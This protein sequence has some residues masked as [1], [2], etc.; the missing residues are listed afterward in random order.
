MSLALVAP[1]VS[2]T[3]GGERLLVAGESAADQFLASAF[4]HPAAGW[5]IQ[6]PLPPR[7]SD[8]PTVVPVDSGLAVGAAHG[9]IP[10]SRTGGS[11]YVLDGGTA[12]T[13]ADLLG[14]AGL[15]KSVRVLRRKLSPSILVGPGVD[16]AGKSLPVTVRLEPLFP[17]PEAVVEILGVGNRSGGPP[18]VLDVDTPAADVET[19]SA[20][21]DAG[22]AG[23]LIRTGDATR[24]RELLDAI[25]EYIKRRDRSR[26]GAA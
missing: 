10:R 13:V 3:S 8:V 1:R 20:S 4:R 17:G 2:V 19:I 26:A 21:L 22:A 6:D 18:L 23:A 16:P 12:C 15:R 7:L 9:V 5:L 11:V 14:V 24:D 25:G